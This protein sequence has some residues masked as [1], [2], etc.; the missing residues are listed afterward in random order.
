MA[1]PPSPRLSA[2]LAVLLPAVAWAAD[3]VDPFAEPD[4]AD[5]FR[6]E[7]RVVTI[8]SR[9]A[10]A[11]GSAPSIVTVITDREIRAR[12]FRTLGDALGSLPGVH[13]TVSKESRRLAWF[14]GV[15]GSDNNKILLLIDGTP[16]YDGVYTHAWIDEYIPLDHVRQIEVIKGPGSAIYGTNAF[17]GVVN[18]V[19]YKGVDLRGGSARVSAGSD[20]RWG[21]SAVV[22]D[23]VETTHGPPVSY[24]AIAR[25]VDIDGDGLDTTPEGEWN[26]SGRDPRRSINAGLQLEVGAIEITLDAV[27]YR[28]LKLVNAQEDALAVL[29]ENPDLFGFSYHNQFAAL[30]VRLHP[31]DDLDLTPYVTA[32]HH[33]NPSLYA[34][35]TGPPVSVTGNAVSGYDAAFDATMIAPR[36]ETLWGSAGADF[37]WRPATEHTLTG[38]I[39]AEMLKVIELAD[40]EFTG[41][42]AGTPTGFG[43]AG[44][45]DRTSDIFGFAQHTWNASWWLELT[46]GVRLDLYSNSVDTEI[47]PFLSPRAGVLVLPTNQTTIKLLYGRAHR[48]ANVREL[49]VVTNQDEAGS[50]RW[51]SGNSALEPEFIDTIEAE[52][53]VSMPGNLTARGGT[54]VSVI[55]QEINQITEDA[56]VPCVKAQTGEECLGD[57]YYEN[58]GESQVLG[59]EGGLGYAVRTWDAEISATYTRASVCIADDEGECLGT[60]RT[61]YGFP[62]LLAHGRL[63]WSPD[64]V[65]ALTGMVD[66]VGTRPRAEWTPNSG[67]DDGP[68]YGLVHLS[69][70]TEVIA[71]GRVRADVSVRNVLN[72]DFRH[73]VYLD[74]ADKTT[75]NDAGKT[76]AKNPEDIEGEGRTIVVTV[77][78]R[79]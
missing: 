41:E 36:K 20:G 64:D 10:Q 7:Q 39:G 47:L 25:V 74:D 75:T 66:Y 76:V 15:I 61:Q 77:E 43:V 78:G 22:G 14:R 16:W 30:R 70:A 68:A 21:V 4:E 63:T 45:G 65:L 67:L 60:W 8:A 29:L 48:A 13:V 71:D 51:T 73:L 72:T 34:Y 54:F 24:R 28:H 59:L 27:N 38:G 58:R 52:A 79:F 53:T 37:T 31:G 50:N 2:S 56:P 69:A 62:P 11:L 35:F 9:Y 46:G 12:G 26:A 32:Q 49:L 57:D 55:G 33:D 6:A 17:A 40:Y 18:V 5:L 23:S 42:S 19:T 3:P 1:A 44:D